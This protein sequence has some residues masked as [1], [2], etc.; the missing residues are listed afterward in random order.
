ME[1]E[2]KTEA[3]ARAH[4]LGRIAGLNDARLA[5]WGIG[6]DKDETALRLRKMTSEKIHKIKEILEI[7]Y[8]G[9]SWFDQAVNLYKKHNKE[10]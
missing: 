7:K 9:D 3:E 10:T 5:F 1:N 6:Y 2:I 4:L 8:I